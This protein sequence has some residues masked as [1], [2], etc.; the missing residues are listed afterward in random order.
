MMKLLK[1]LKIYKIVFKSPSKLPNFFSE[2]GPFCSL[3]NAI[4]I[5]KFR[6]NGRPACWVYHGLFHRDPCP[7]QS[8]YAII[9]YTCE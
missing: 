8:K 2:N 7:G 6:C 9:S 3:E 4:V 1:P 5:P